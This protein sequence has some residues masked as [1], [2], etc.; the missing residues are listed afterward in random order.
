MSQQDQTMERIRDAFRLFCRGERAEGRAMLEAIWHELGPEG[1][2]FHRSV[3]AHYLADT[4]DDPLGELAWD[5]RALET[6]S[7]LDEERA[8]NQPRAEA[9]RAFLPSLHLSVADDYRRMGDFEKAS[10]HVDLGAELSQGLGQD[11]Y[12]QTIRTRL[13]EITTQIEERDSGP[14]I[15]FEL[16]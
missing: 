2:I 8:L 5:L 6:A 12:A 11:T 9:V 3:T 10:H 15:V 4:E 13:I 16:E 14:L 7:S 1:D